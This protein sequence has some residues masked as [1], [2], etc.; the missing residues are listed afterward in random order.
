M[1]ILLK[2]LDESLRLFVRIS[3]YLLVGFAISG[4]LHMFVDSGF[5]IRN[6]KSGKSSILKAVALGVPLPV[7]SCGVIPI[8]A[9]FK[10]QG[11]SKASILAFLYSTPVTG[12]D[13]ILVTYALLGT[14]FAIFRPMAA[15][16]GGILIG[17]IVLKFAHGNG[18]E[19][20]HD[21]RVH[22][23]GKKSL[24]EA[25]G[26]SFSY[27]P[28]EIGKWIIAG[29]LLG[30]IV[31]VMIPADIGRYLSNPYLAYPAVLLISIPLYVCATGSVP[32]AAAFIA[33]G[34]SP[35][36]AL[37]FLIAGPATNTVTITFVLKDLGKKFAAI[38]LAGIALTSVAFGIIF[39]ELIR[40][41]GIETFVRASVTTGSV[42]IISQISAVILAGIIFFALFKPSITL[43]KKEEEEMKLILKVPGMMCEGCVYSI[44]SKLLPLKE[45][46]NV[47]VDLGS[48]EVYVDTDLP[49]EVIK[50]AINEA[51]YEVEEITI[52][53]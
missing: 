38:Y 30:G 47:K 17:L 14:A 16:V 46:K 13:S 40:I 25:F 6:L 50:E 23:G 5:V 28:G 43:K 27:L 1:D 11:A 15:F 4:I 34:L 44:K 52:K 49:A 3:P 51:G 2:I 33:K 21:T 22:S 41:F 24:K 9:S 35:G 53:S 8:A 37:A 31:S 36:A 7:C 29:V 48:H 10:R 12:V 26:Y 42:G 19:D 39:D 18:A 32:V 45:V 20:H